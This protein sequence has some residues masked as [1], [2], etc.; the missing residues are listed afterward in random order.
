MIDSIFNKKNSK[1]PTGT[2]E[3]ADHN[4]NCVNGCFHDCR[5]CYA[6]IMANR[7]GRAIGKNWRD[8]VVRKEAV[9]KKYGRYHGRIMF[10]TSHDIV[11]IPEVEDAC[12]IVLE[13]IL[14]K[15]NEIL[16]TTKPS[17]TIIKHIDEKFFNYKKNLQFRFTITSLDNKL[18]KFWEPNAPL[19]EERLKSLQFAFKKGYKT[20]VSIEPF[21]DFDPQP[22]VDQISPYI[23][24]SIWI[25]IMNYISQ[26]NLKGNEITFYNSIRK[27]YT[28]KNL[29]TIY[30]KLNRNPKIRWKDSIKKRLK[31]IL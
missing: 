15:D 24:E 30:E 20:S 6:K 23:T 28:E 27:N 8:M 13:K 7:F 14:K 17:F 21:L 12:F 3:W 1:I 18:L 26:K 22:L 16:L 10:P 4:I 11:N 29:K 31:L 19:F 5:Y 25:G 2:K 9:N